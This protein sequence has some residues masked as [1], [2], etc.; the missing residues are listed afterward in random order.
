VIIRGI[1]GDGRRRNTTLLINEIRPQGKKPFTS[2][3]K[4]PYVGTKLPFNK[5]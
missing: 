4:N 1:G 5:K 3:P 2:A